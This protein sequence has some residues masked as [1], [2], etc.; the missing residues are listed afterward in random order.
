MNAARAAAAEKA[1]ACEVAARATWAE[2]GTHRPDLK[3]TATQGLKKWNFFLS[4]TQRDDAAKLLASELWAELKMKH[5]LDSWLDVKMPSRDSGAMEAGVKEA[6]CFI[7][8]ITDNGKDSYFSREM[9][10]QEIAWA[11]QY[12]KPIVAVVQ[13]E[14][15]KKIGALVQEAKTHGLDFSR[16]DFCTYDRTGPNQAPERG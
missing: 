6:D 3:R 2:P 9:C 4:H 13:A 8:I 10:R 5:G 1:T 7:A 14:D 15:K 11:A 16:I 12:G